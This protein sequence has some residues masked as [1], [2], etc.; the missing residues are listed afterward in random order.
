MKREHGDIRT[1]PWEA[2]LSEYLDDE[3]PGPER[4]QLEDHLR[5]C[6]SCSAVLGELRAVVARAGVYP[7][8]SMP[9]DDLWEGIRPRLQPRE[10]TLWRRAIAVFNLPPAAPA[11]WRMPAFAAIAV[12]VVGLAAS[13]VWLR[14]G[15]KLRPYEPGTREGTAASQA[16]ASQQDATRPEKPTAL[17]ATREY[18]D[19]VAELRRVVER[20]LTHD[21]RVVEVLDTNLAAIDAAIAGYRDALAASPDDEALRRRLD[22]ARERKVDVLRQAAALASEATN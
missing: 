20:S 8:E 4:R 1:D 10:K 5:A 7:R 16:P 15:S 17:E 2:R 21:P 18:Y 3:L 6:A 12:L 22:R 19:T 9:A 14:G 11:W 13:L